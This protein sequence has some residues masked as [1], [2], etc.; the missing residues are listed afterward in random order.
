MDTYHLAYPTHYLKKNILTM[1]DKKFDISEYDDRYFEWH[2]KHARI[3]AINTM[4]WYVQKYKP[5]SVIDFGCGIGA[6]LESALKNGISKIEGYDIGG[7]HVK[8][9]TPIEIQEFIE[10]ADCTNILYTDKYECVISL[11][12]AEHIEPSGTDNF[13]LNIVNSV[14][15]HGVILFSAAPPGQGGTGHINCQTIR[16]TIIN[17]RGNNITNY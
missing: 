9:F 6:Y 4:D 14:D 13:V 11:E 17:K 5:S 3:Y 2:S 8:K 1:D 16:R 15:K 10:Y 12:T 7:E